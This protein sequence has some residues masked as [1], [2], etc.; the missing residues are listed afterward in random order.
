M[1]MQAMTA[2]KAEMK[3]SPPKMS[4]KVITTML[5]KYRKMKPRMAKTTPLGIWDP[6]TV[7]GAARVGRFWRAYSM[8]G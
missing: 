6:P 5:V 4:R 1:L 3:S 7:T 2:V 8:A